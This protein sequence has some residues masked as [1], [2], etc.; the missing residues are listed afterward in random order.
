MPL[1][2]N[3]VGS[4]CPDAHI[5][6]PSLICWRTP[7]NGWWLHRDDVYGAESLQRRS[8]SSRP[9][10]GSGGSDQQR[11]QVSAGGNSKG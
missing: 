11:D 5:N 2:V 3:A 9:S 6:C 8:N 4:A 1:P 7:T 10:G